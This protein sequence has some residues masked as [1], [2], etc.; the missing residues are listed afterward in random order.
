M[1]TLTD[2]QA[3][4]TRAENALTAGYQI[5]RSPGSAF[6]I[7]VDIEPAPTQFRDGIAGSGGFQSGELARHSGIPRKAAVARPTDD[8]YL[9]SRDRVRIYSSLV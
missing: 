6:R 3:N 9:G 7:T 4:A 5:L 2:L 8:T 1:K